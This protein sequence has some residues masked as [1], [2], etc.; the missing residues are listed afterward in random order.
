MPKNP[1]APASQTRST[2]PAQSF[3]IFKIPLPAYT[4]KNVPPLTILT[5]KLIFPTIIKTLF[6]T[7]T[8]TELKAENDPTSKSIFIDKNPSPQPS[9]PHN[10]GV[11]HEYQDIATF[12]PHP[13]PSLPLLDLGLP[14][15][16]PLDPP[17]LYKV[18]DF[19]QLA[20]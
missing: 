3:L 2:A 10:L 9:N 20:K 16:T 14:S 7:R 8:F 5:A 12:A 4:L 13:L 19:Y 1:K 6:Y 15:G 18:L 17:H 11:N